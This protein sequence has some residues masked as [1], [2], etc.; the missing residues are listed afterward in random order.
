MLVTTKSSISRFLWWSL[1]KMKYERHRTSLQAYV[2]ARLCGDYFFLIHNYFQLR[3]WRK[4]TFTQSQNVA[5]WRGRSVIILTSVNSLWLLLRH[6]SVVSWG[7]V[8]LLCN[9]PG[10]RW[11]HWLAER[12][13]VLLSPTFP[14]DCGAWR[15]HLQV[16][17][18]KQQQFLMSTVELE[19]QEASQQMSADSCLV[20][21][22][23]FDCEYMSHV[24]PPIVSHVSQQWARDGRNN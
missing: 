7:V 2:F 1:S 16:Y 13:T 8:W 5:V 15:A 23:H 9:S 22:R 11:P 20:L 3:M 10:G 19:M 6:L 14:T 17:S 24:S 18:A 21:D 12:A 4:Q